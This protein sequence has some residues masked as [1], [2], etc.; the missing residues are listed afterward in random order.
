MLKSLQR[1]IYS[2]LTL[3]D[4]N[5]ILDKLEI[6]SG[7]HLYIHSSSSGICNLKPDNLSNREFLEKIIKLIQD[8]IGD[9]GIL[10]MPS[11]SIKG[12]SISYWNSFPTFNVLKTPGR[13]GF[14][15][16]VLRKSIP[17]V[18]R[19]IHPTE[20]VIAWGNI[21]DI[22]LSDHYKFSMAPYHKNTPLGWMI[23][24]KAKILHF[25]LN[26]TKRIS[27]I[28]FIDSYLNDLHDF[29]YL[30]KKPQ[31]ARITLQ[32]NT[33]LEIFGYAYNSTLTKHYNRKILYQEMKLKSLVKFKFKGIRFSS[34]DAKE[35]FDNAVKSGS[36]SLVKGN[37]PKWIRI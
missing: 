1:K 26:Y 11:F 15:T 10:M 22:I 32:D 6:K 3:S 20:S 12:D 27:L 2:D 4:I 31:K 21:P 36:E 13:N 35:S 33:T 29:N 16:E 28:H 23:N 37:L 17:G 5:L 18:K 30:I 14:F 34:F 25:G 19:S 24:N 7:D 9:S 8:R